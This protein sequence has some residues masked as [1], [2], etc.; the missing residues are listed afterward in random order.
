MPYVPLYAIAAQRAVERWQREELPLYRTVQSILAHPAVKSSL[1]GM[2]YSTI[3]SVTY[4]HSLTVHNCDY[5]AALNILHNA[6]R[7]LDKI[8]Y[9]ERYSGVR[10]TIVAALMGGNISQRYLTRALK[11][12]F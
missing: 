4:L 7:T 2:H 10:T 9:V 5:F 8:K 6:Q 11:V 3:H 1:D 12:C